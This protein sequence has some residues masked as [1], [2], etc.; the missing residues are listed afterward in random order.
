MSGTPGLSAPA[1]R[2]S[3]PREELQTGVRTAGDIA[4]DVIRVPALDLDAAHRVARCDAPSDAGREALDKARAFTA[5]QDEQRLGL[6]ALAAIL[7]VSVYRL[8]SAARDGR[9][10]VTYGNRTVFTTTTPLNKSVPQ[11][12]STVTAEFQE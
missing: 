4:A 3:G 8:R 7:G 2:K 5:G 11:T 12:K 9:L 6:P 10:A 1:H